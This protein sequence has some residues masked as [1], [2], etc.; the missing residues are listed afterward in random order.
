[1]AQLCLYTETLRNPEYSVIKEYSVTYRYQEEEEEEEEEDTLSLQ[2]NSLINLQL[3]YSPPRDSVLSV[4]TRRQR[5]VEVE[6]E[7]DF[8]KLLGQRL[9][10][11][12][13]FRRHHSRSLFGFRIRI[14]QS[15][16]RPWM[17]DYIMR[18]I[19]DFQVVSS[20]LVRSSVLPLSLVNITECLER[21]RVSHLHMSFNDI[22]INVASS[23][24][25][26]FFRSGYCKISRN[27]KVCPTKP[28]ILRVIQVFLNGIFHIIF[29]YFELL[30]YLVWTIFDVL[31]LNQLL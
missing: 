31:F 21:F 2:L 26:I 25:N 28:V 10:S 15:N 27:L 7:L 14:K 16:L 23:F 17:T 13:R 1:M 4:L 9:V 12:L 8:G 6:V 18:Y 30:C 20:Q 5:P 3:H 19:I 11:F 22:G 29:C 24:N